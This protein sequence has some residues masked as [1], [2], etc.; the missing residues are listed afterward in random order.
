[1]TSEAIRN[2][3]TDH[4]LTPENSAL[5]IIDYPTTP[6][7]PPPGPPPSTTRPGH[8]AASTPTPSASSLAHGSASSGALG[9]TDRPTIPNTTPRPPKPQP[10]KFRVDTGCLTPRR[11]GLDRMWRLKRVDEL[12]VWSLSCFHVRKGGRFAERFRD[13]P[14]FN[15]RPRRLAR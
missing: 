4:L 14:C 11:P 15:L 10:N 9:K 3:Q 8:V 13:R 6:G 2:P 5:I 12:P 7:M 1:M